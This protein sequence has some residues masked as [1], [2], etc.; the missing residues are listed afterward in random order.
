MASTVTRQEV[1]AVPV[2]VSTEI[3]PL[4]A[5]RERFSMQCQDLNCTWWVTFEAE[6]AAENNGFVFSGRALYNEADIIPQKEAALE[7]YQ[8]PVNVF[9]TAAGGVT[10]VNFWV[11]EVE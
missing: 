2:R 4:N 3:S 1:V 8:G 11:M 6:V 5:N 9:V 10:A 7:T